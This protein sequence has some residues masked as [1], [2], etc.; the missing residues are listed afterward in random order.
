MI[1][2]LA[3][4]VA[5][6]ACQREPLPVPTRAEIY[7]YDLEWTDE[8]MPCLPGR[9]NPKCDKSKKPLT[10]KDT[11]AATINE[12]L[13]DSRSYQP[14][15]QMKC[16]E[17]RHTIAFF[18]GTSMLDVANVCFECHNVDFSG[19]S[20]PFAGCG[21]PTESPGTMTFTAGAYA[22]LRSLLVAAKVKNLPPKEIKE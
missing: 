7:A 19:G 11:K 4:L 20:N 12:L 13:R 10:V 21:A 1:V 2:L 16:F 22:K 9:D 5:A 8:Q 14:D 17:P 6:P 15:V 3:L 18:Y